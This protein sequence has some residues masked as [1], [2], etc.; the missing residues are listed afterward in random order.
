MICE[1]TETSH[2]QQ[3]THRRSS[4]GVQ[5]LAY[6]DLDMSMRADGL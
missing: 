3:S 2:T 4:R 6:F 5:L 1:C